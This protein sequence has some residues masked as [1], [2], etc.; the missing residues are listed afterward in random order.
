MNNSQY[1]KILE[2][3]LDLEKKMDKRFLEAHH[4]TANAIV[5]AVD[6]GLVKRE[7]EDLLSQKVIDLE[8]KFD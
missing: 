7:M 6:I 4:E 5:N 3:M 1:K 8:N 2:L